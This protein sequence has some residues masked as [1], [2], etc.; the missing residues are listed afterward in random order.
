M[1]GPGQTAATDRRPTR[2]C[3]QGQ[4]G[5]GRPAPGSARPAGTVSN[6]AVSAIATNAATFHGRGRRQPAG[7]EPCMSSPD[8]ALF[9]I[10]PRR[11]TNSRHRRTD[12]EK[13]KEA[14]RIIRT[15]YHAAFRIRMF[16]H[17]GIEGKANRMDVHDERSRQG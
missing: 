16:I 3:R 14:R 11:K 13:T 4:S 10:S 7:L 5:F 17:A 8:L 12:V 15:S 1:E 2:I 6:R 9:N